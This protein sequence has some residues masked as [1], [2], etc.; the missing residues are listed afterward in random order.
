M[1]R[2]RQAHVVVVCRQAVGRKRPVNVRGGGGVGVVVQPVLGTVLPIV[3][4]HCLGLGIVNWVDEGH[5]DRAIAAAAR[6]VGGVAV[7]SRH[8]DRRYVERISSGCG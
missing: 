5:G 6:I 7:L 8:C 3:A 2:V 1:L 4:E